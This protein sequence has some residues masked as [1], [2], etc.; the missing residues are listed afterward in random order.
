MKIGVIGA[1]GKEGSLIVKEAVDRGLDVT[2]IVRDSKKSPT[3]QYLVRDVYS[4]QAEDVKDFDVLVDA[5]GFFG[6][7]VK[8]YV[9][10]TKHLIE[11]L[12]GTKTR[13]LVVGG[14]GS[15]YVDEN[16]TKQL[17]QQADFP[18]AV[19][20][21]SEEMGKSLDVLRASDI[22]WTFISPAA[23]FEAKGKKTSEYVLAGEELTFD[24]DNK[25][26]I[27]YADF[28]LAMVDEIINAKHQKE[29]ISVRW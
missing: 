2:S 13:L 15:L 12:E 22:N 20:P 6:P 4:L 1:N 7:A 21:L 19:K 5:L 29:R 10:A 3:D 26:V 16:H 17:Y 28:A 9:P 25:S 11:I 14:A 24:K 27:S 23:D 18:E 8:E